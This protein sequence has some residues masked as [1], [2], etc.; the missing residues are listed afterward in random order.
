MKYRSQ[1]EGFVDGRAIHIFLLGRLVPP[2]YL[3]EF[4]PSP[5]RMA[6]SP[7]LTRYNGS[8]GG[9]RSTAMY[10]GSRSCSTSKGCRQCRNA[11]SSD[12]FHVSLFHKLL[13]ICPPRDH[14][15]SSLHLHIPINFPPSA[16]H[17]DILVPLP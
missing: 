5:A 8:L 10:V 4:W 2:S 13:N 7:V 17:H 3:V 1:V 15:F 11:F 6:N 14:N 16:K 9:T 12:Q